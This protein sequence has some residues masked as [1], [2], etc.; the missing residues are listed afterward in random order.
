MPELPE[1]ETALRGVSPYLKDY[2]IE[3]I[4]VRQPKLRWVVSPELT[5]FHHVK[6]LDLTRRAKY[7]IIHSEQGYIIGHLGMSGTVRIVPHDSPIDKHVGLRRFSMNPNNLLPVKNI[8]LHS[9]TALLETETAKILRSED[10]Y[11]KFFS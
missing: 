1:V 8:I 11:F 9:N 5:E 7:L 6:I 4:V 2:V 10:S 3:K